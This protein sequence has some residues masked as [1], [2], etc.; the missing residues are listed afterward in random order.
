MK[1]RSPYELEK[2]LD[3]DL[4]WRKREFTTLKF[5]LSSTRAH[6]RQVLLRASIALLYSHWE[7]H[8][9]FCALVYLSYL[10]SLGLSYQQMTDNFLQLSLGEKFNNGF[11]IK[12]FPSQKEIF[13]YIRSEQTSSFSINEDVVIDTQSNLKYEVIFNIL[14]QLGL[15][16]SA[17]E[18]K[19]NFINSKLLKCRNQIAHGERCSQEDL[20][21]T[22]EELENELLGMIITFQNMIRNAVVNREYLK[23]PL[24]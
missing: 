21:N 4:A 11:S 14:E 7:G 19:E 6:E 1:V 12:K 8:I 20:E 9:K 16:S 23:K 13:N 17:F 24:G 18:L 3:E 10:N 15:D 22:Y 5:M 2:K